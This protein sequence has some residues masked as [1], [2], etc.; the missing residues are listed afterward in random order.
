MTHRDIAAVRAR[1]EKAVGL[2]PGEPACPAE[3]YLSHES[4]AIAIL[5]SEYMDFESG[6]LEEYLLTY[7]QLKRFELGLSP[8]VQD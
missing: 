6:L 4:V 1:L 7:L 2:L 5:D 8:D 3:A